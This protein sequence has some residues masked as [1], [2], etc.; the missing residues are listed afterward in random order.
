MKGDLF[1]DKGDYYRIRVGDYRVICVSGEEDYDV[2]V[3]RAYHRRDAYR[4][5]LA[6]G[7]L[8]QPQRFSAFL[9]DAIQTPLATMA[10]MTSEKE[11]TVSATEARSELSDLISRAQYSEERI[12]LTRHDKPVAALVS[13]EDLKA[14]RKLEDTT[15]VQR[16]RESI[17]DAR[18]HGGTKPLKKFR[19]ELEAG[20]DK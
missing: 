17:E 15:D 2:L 3:A 10:E 14:L 9:T 7:A 5:A 19:E 11:R 16:A 6:S 1:G 8:A 18:K 4:R 20:R 12:I 13:I